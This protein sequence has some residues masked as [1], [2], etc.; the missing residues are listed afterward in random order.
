MACCCAR[1][2]VSST[3]N[4]D[5]VLA[6]LSGFFGGL[7][8]L[9]A[10]IGVYGV[11][12]DAVTRRRTE[13][14]IRMALGAQAADVM[15]V[16]F[17]QIAILVGVGI[18]TGALLSAWASPFAASLLYGLEPRDPAT[19]AGA[20]LTITLVAGLAGWL[21]AYRASRVDPAH[22]LRAL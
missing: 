7:A 10:A 11:A 12:A 19:F 22:A 21:P 18:A 1:C 13:I 4:Q 16:T 17:S 3:L 14:G 2:Q 20:A 5:R 9:L 8:L 6:M 15:R